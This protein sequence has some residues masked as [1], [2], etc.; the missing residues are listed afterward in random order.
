MARK[1][2]Y[3]A[4]A[5]DA[6]RVVSRQAGDFGPPRRRRPRA[7]PGLL[8]CLTYPLT[9][10]PGVGLLVLLAPLLLLLSLPVFDVIAIIE[11]LSRGDFALGL[12]VLPIV[13]PMATTLALVLG[14]GLLFLGQTFVAS[15]LG[16]PEHPRWPG[17]DSSQ[18][19][20]GLGRWAWAGV[21]GLLLGG[22]P[23][24]VY[25]TVCGDLDWFDYVV[26]ADLVFLGVG[27]ALVALAASLLHDSLV[28]ANPFTVLMA[29][30]QFGWDFVM[31][32]VTGGLAL[33][34]AGGA[35]YG[36]LFCIPSL[37]TAVA[38]L[39]GFWV[40]ALYETMVVLRMVGLTYYAHADEL[41]WFRGRPKWGLPARF[42]K[43]Y[44][45]S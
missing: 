9:D 42:G 21:F 39:W 15:A 41:V 16:E 31:P 14:W 43:I 6:V 38:A 1:S 23:V 11:P 8:E 18:I 40:L 32:C 10:G 20:E 45:N 37:P 30:G 5:S 27:Y 35:L 12:L 25:W 2:W 34:V 13:T 4:S 17:W 22:V 28:M 7:A 26:F 24:V 33:I 19:A 44:S 36:V 3:D 29:I